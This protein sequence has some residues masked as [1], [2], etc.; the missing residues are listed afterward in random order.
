MGNSLGGHPNIVY[1]TERLSADVGGGYVAG[2][3]GHQRKLLLPRR[4]RRAASFGS[5]RAAQPVG[6]RWRGR[7]P[8]F[9]A[10]GPS[11]AASWRLGYVGVRPR[12]LINVGEVS[13]V[14]DGRRAQRAWP[15]CVGACVFG[16]LSRP[17]VSIQT[18]AQ[19]AHPLDLRNQGDFG[20]FG[21]AHGWCHHDGWCQPTAGG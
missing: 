10:V 21:C 13:S 4:Y 14:A 16:P 18:A 2:D 11:G 1:W 9:A 15:F 6:C 8:R 12:A 19:P 17:R 20:T 7:G 5:T 3:S